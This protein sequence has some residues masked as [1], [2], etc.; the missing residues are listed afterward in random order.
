MKYKS[1]SR[2]EV[3]VQPAVLQVSNSTLEIMKALIF[4]DGKTEGLKA[5]L[6]G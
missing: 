3:F 6:K 1:F 5:S 4:S 2:R